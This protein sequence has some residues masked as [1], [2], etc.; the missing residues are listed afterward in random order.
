MIQQFFQTY[1]QDQENQLEFVFC[2]LLKFLVQ[3]VD[4]E[5]FC[6]GDPI[7]AEP[8]GII[9]VNPKKYPNVQYD[10]AMKFVEWIISAK[11]QKL[12]DGYQFEDQ[13]GVGKMQL[14]YA[15]VLQK[16]V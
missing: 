8:Y 1:A 11:G 6:E 5:I 3:K 10:L 13:Y 12:I 15:D 14:F 2:F 16:P 9:P 7:L 4:L